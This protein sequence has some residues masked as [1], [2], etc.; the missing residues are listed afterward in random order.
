VQGHY[1][2]PPVS[3][4]QATA[5]LSQHEQGFEYGGTLAAG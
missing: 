5:M 2:S 3:S 1:F 4:H